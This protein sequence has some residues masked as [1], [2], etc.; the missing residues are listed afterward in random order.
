MKPAPFDYYA[1]ASVDEALTLLAE[2]G[3]D[4][5]LL[6]GGQS[7]VPAMNFRLAQP[8]VL[9]DLNRIDS[10]SF[11]T[12]ADAASRVSMGAMTRQAAV[13]NSEMVARIAPLLHETMPHIAHSQIRNRGTIGGSIAHADPASELPVIM[14]VLQAKFTLRSAN[15]ERTLPA[16]DFF[17]GLFTTALEPEEILAEISIAAPQPRTGSAFQEVARRR[18]DYA[19]VGVACTVT[20]DANHVCEHARIGLLS[21]GEG[22]VMAAE[23]SRQLIGQKGTA[24]QVCEVAQVVAEKDIDPPNDIHASADFRR[25]LARVLTE[26]ALTTAFKRAKRAQTQG[27]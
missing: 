18:G 25:H 14:S 27:K 11:I 10:L 5:K 1:P 6:A 7:L 9:I 16:E 17:V 22:P 8:A 2:H 20:L 24:R 3:Y 12:Q 23:A 26:R 19:L 4:A 21:V 15:G 13:E